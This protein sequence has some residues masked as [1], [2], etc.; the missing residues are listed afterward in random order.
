MVGTQPVGEICKAIKGWLRL[1]AVSIILVAQ[2]LLASSYLLSV[3][4][5]QPK[6]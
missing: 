2:I 4:L 6:T 1:S 3:S 5:Y